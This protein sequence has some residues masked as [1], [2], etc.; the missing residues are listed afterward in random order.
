MKFG[1]QIPGTVEEAMELDRGAENNLWRE[2]IEKEWENSR[3]AFQLL[4][5]GKPPP[6]GYKE[7][8]CQ[9]VFNIKLNMT[10]K[11]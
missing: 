4:E 6:V 5:R 8:T 10:R 2:A 3:V 9:L 7:I 11:A 1:I